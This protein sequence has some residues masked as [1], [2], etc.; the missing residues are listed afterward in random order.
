MLSLITF[1][2]LSRDCGILYIS[3]LVSSRPIQTGVE[4]VA[5]IGRRVVEAELLVNGIDLLDV[6]VVKLEVALQI[7]LD[8]GWCLRLWDDG[9]PTGDTP[10]EGDLSSVL[11]VLLA[12]LVE[13]CVVNELAHV[14]T[15]GVNL[16]LVAEGRVVGNVNTLLLVEVGEAVLLEP[17][18]TFELTAMQIRIG[19]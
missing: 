14:L 11:A 8:A 17:W 12:N 7:V 1:D 6:G 3:G 16:V 15:R 4:L 2:V 13:Q 10:G 9:M 5:E 18:V 19:C